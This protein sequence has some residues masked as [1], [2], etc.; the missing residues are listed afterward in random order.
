M[1]ERFTRC[2]RCGRKARLFECK[3]CGSYYCEEHSDPK[4]PLTPSMVFN[5]KNPVLSQLYEKEWRK[6]GHPCVPYGEWKLN[7]VMKEDKELTDKI[8]GTLDKMKEV[9]LRRPQI[10]EKFKPIKIPWKERY[11]APHHNFINERRNSKNIFKNIIIAIIFFAILYLIYNNQNLISNS[12]TFKYI[13]NLFKNHFNIDLSGNFPLIFIGILSVIFILFF[14]SR[15]AIKVIVV[16]IIAVLLVLIFADTLGS[17][18]SSDWKKVSGQPNINIGELEK[19]IHDLVNNERHSYGLSMLQLDSKLSDVA[20]AHS[21]DMSLNEYFSH[22]NLKGQDPT[23]RA[24]SAGYS[25]FKSYGGYYTN[26]IA[27][28]IFQNNLY[29]SVTF[30]EGVPIYSWN[31]QSELASST[32][33]GW[34]SS[35]GHRQNILTATYDREGIGIAISS[36]DKIYITQDFC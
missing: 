1:R 21:V 9:P 7:E 5:E 23:A 25:C 19:E 35:T 34:M 18:I 2:L 15:T 11:K 32:V 16:F 24:T 30:A 10:F 28:N 31:S 4:M 29:S 17:P 6:G 13:I 22:V 12:S 3:H 33:N 27:E 26:G 20:R 8:M 14:I 36:D